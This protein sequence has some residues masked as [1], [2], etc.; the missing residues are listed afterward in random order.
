MNAP[1][2][3]ALA[4]PAALMPLGLLAAALAWMAL[5]PERPAA[6]LAIVSALALGVALW[7]LE[8]GRL[9]ESAERIHGL[10][11]NLGEL[12]AALEH[13]EA[14]RTAAETALRASEE[15]YVVALRGSQDGMWE[16]DLGADK[17]VLSP[18]WKSMLGYASDELAD[19]REG[20]L[21]CVHPDDRAP[22]QQALQRHLDSPDVRFD[23]EMRLV[24]K[25][26]SV[27]WVLSRGVAI[28]HAS[29]APY[30]MIGMDSD[31]T[32][33]K[34]VETVLDA[35][36]HGTSGAF[37]DALFSAMVEHFARALEVDCAFI[38]ECADH[39]PTRVRTL[40]HWSEGRCRENVEYALPG[41]PCEQVINGARMCFHRSGLHRLY[42]AEAGYESYLGIPIVA[43]DGRVLGHL[44]FLDREVRGEEM[45]VESIYRIFTARAAAEM[46]RKQALQ[47]LSAL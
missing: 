45:L 1:P 18:R 19:T 23:H 30:R 34:R 6:A 42:P 29:G 15:R 13:S 32:R 16:W 28:R 43:S 36:A 33:L 25:D 4:H 46:E 37:G 8:R 35:V 17:V 38:T 40:A 20:W 3:S 39:P 44:A 2:R 26:G 5:D 47:R 21:G 7:R 22:L 12:R 10:E 11:Q 9:D 27:R 24:H 14:T 41:T 31:V